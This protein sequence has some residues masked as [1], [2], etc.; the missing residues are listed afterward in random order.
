MIDEKQPSK[1][2]PEEKSGMDADKLHEEILALLF[3]VEELFSE[4]DVPSSFYMRLGYLVSD[5]RQLGRGKSKS[6]RQLAA[7][8]ALY[9][10]R[11]S[12]S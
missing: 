10:F 8:L 3:R 12:T 6:A 11:Q 7:F 1:F 5:L 4:F 2:E 9:E